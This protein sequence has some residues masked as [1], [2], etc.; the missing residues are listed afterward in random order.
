MRY[1]VMI[2]EKLKIAVEKSNLVLK[3][4][5]FD[6]EDS[7]IPTSK[8]INSIKSLTGAKIGID[9]V[10]FSKL[11]IDADF[12]AMMRV[13]KNSDNT[14]TAEIFINS[15]RDSSYQRFSLVHE[16]GHLITECYNFSPDN[17]KFTLSTHIN[18]SVFSIDKEAY[19]KSEYLLNE[20]IA[21]VFALRT[22]IPFNKLIERLEENSDLN[23]IAKS[24][25]VTKD[26]I[27]SRIALGV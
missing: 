4:V 27:I 14:K 12:G 13:T 9:Y 18:Q 19:D 17:K 10:S 2:D 1:C 6:N 16:L 21:N 23:K 25:G 20:Q 15:D 3:T 26:A 24:F 5:N 22:L 11:E 8:I 7:I